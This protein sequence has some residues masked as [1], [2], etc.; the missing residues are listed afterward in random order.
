MTGQSSSQVSVRSTV[1]RSLIG[2]PF[3][4]SA[5]EIEG[6]TAS[7]PPPA[8]LPLRDRRKTAHLAPKHVFRF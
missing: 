8:L 5:V 2:W 1:G 3:F 7:A 4:L 6:R